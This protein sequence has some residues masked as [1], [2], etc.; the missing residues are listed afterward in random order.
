MGMGIVTDKDF[1]REFDKLNPH[2]KPPQPRERTNET[3]ASIIEELKKGRGD[4]NIEVPNALRNIIGQTAIE[5]GRQ[6]ALELAK[7]FGISA[8]SA[9]AYANGATSTASYHEKPNGN[10]I[11][12]TKEKIARRARGKLMLALSHITKDR[13]E[14]A[15]LR[16][17]SGVAKDMSIIA[18]NMEPSAEA[19]DATKSGPTFVFYSPQVTE[20][21]KFEVIHTKE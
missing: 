17:V 9:S 15:T 2:L 13:L 4:G 20:E 10:I 16:D 21:K 1:D 18:K 7:R 11:N 12:S 8:S 14:S 5:S 19:P 6:E 3:P